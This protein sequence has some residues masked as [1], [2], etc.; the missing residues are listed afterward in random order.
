[1]GRPRGFDEQAVTAAAELFDDGVSVGDLVQQLGVHR[2]SL[3]NTFGSERGHHYAR[4]V[5]R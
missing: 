3:H 2:D 4:L 5:T 1:M